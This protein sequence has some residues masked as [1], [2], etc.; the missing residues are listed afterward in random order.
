M[1]KSLRLSGMFEK[2]SIESEKVHYNLMNIS[3]K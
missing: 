1:S 3:I 2:L